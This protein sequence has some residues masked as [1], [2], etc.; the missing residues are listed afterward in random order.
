[1]GAMVGLVDAATLRAVAADH[2][3]EQ[4]TVAAD[5]MQS[6]LFVRPDDDL[7]D[8]VEQMVKSGFREL[9]VLDDRGQIVGFLDEADVTRVY[10]ELTQEVTPR[11]R[12][13][14]E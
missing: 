7:H 11:S 5:V 12:P 1:M 14:G 4:V 8:A 9:P 6:P 3:I 13:G 10:L 2:E